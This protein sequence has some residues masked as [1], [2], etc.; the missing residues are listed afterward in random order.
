[1]NPFRKNVILLLNIS[2]F[3]FLLI[4]LHQWQVILVSCYCVT[5]LKYYYEQG[6]FY[7]CRISCGDFRRLLWRSLI[8]YNSI[9]I[10]I[11]NFD[12]L[13]WLDITIVNQSIF[14]DFLQLAHDNFSSTWYN[15]F[16][17]LFSYIWTVYFL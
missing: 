3:F 10:I 2:D 1:M 8:K 13:S 9:C 16:D 11:I 12:N 15:F 17:N 5:V 6:N 14:C 4:N 7:H